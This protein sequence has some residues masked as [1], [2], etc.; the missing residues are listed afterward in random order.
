M[1]KV[2]NTRSS[3]SCFD[4]FYFFCAAQP[5]IRVPL[6]VLSTEAFSPTALTTPVRS[7]VSGDTWLGVITMISTNNH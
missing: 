6:V 3:A 4:Y 5:V 1:V 7:K 2:V